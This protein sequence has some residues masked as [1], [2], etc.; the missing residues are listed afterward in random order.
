M[1][2]TFEL[3]IDQGACAAIA[4]RVDVGT[5]ANGVPA[6]FASVTGITMAHVGIGS[7]S[8]L[9]MIAARPQITESYM[10]KETG[11]VAQTLAHRLIA[12]NGLALATVETGPIITS[13]HR[14]PAVK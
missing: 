8:A 1:A 5:L 9:P 6:S 10:T 14:D 13:S 12:C 11:P 4:A 7:Q 3:A 2:F